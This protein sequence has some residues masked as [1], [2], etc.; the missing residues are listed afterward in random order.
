[1]RKRRKDLSPD[2]LARKE[3]IIEYLTEWPSHDS[4]DSSALIGEMIGQM[5]EGALW[6][7]WGTTWL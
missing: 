6:W 1:M 2:E 7:T 3:L 5:L 4:L